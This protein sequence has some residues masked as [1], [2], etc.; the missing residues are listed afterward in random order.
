MW[1]SDV[2]RAWRCEKVPDPTGGRSWQHPGTPVLDGQQTRR[3]ADVPACAL[4]SSWGGQRSG[5]TE[6]CKERGVHPEPL[7][8]SKS[9]E[10][11]LKAPGHYAWVWSM[12]LYSSALRCLLQVWVCYRVYIDGGCTTQNIAHTCRDNAT[13][14]VKAQFPGAT[15]GSAYLC[16]CFVCYSFL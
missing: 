2:L 14:S 13:H 11:P 6:A 8:P 9:R 5:F 16:A 7:S 3:L 4:C 15:Q 1:H 10:P 12:K